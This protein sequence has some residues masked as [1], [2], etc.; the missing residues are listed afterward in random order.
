MLGISDKPLRKSA[1]T[2][3][4][5]PSIAA[6][7]SDIAPVGPGA[8]PQRK[9]QA[10]HSHADTAPRTKNSSTGGLIAQWWLKARGK[11]CCSVILEP[12]PNTTASAA[13]GEIREAAELSRHKHQRGVVGGPK[14]RL[15]P[16]YASAFGLR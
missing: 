15:A 5:R 16:I 4:A 9:R 10:Y 12:V 11:R 7:I 13:L 8:Y 6:R 1:V 2:G 3:A 14:A